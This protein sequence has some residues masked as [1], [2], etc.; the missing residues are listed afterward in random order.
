[1]SYPGTI[2]PGTYEEG[3][4]AGRAYQNDLCIPKFRGRDIFAAA[5]LKIADITSWFPFDAAGAATE[6]IRIAKEALADAKEASTK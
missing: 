3:F 6:C 1:M 2:R 4:A 5:L